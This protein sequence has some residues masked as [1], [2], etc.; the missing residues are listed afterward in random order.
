[1][2][3][4]VKALLAS[5]ALGVGVVAAGVSAQS[6]VR[7]I[8]GNA[9]LSQMGVF[10]TTVQITSIAN[11]RVRVTLD[12]L[13]DEDKVTLEADAIDVAMVPDGLRLVAKG[14]VTMSARSPVQEVTAVELEI[15]V[16]RDRKA[17]MRAKS[18]TL[19]R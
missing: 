13:K 5:V 3:I 6:Q 12:G 17:L 1:M 15:T 2:T 4:R 9:V 11:Q 18:I 8:T 19:T 10:G 14:P 16:T 7:S